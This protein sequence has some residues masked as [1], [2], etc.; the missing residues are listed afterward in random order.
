MP[1]AN[2]TRDINKTFLKNTIRN[3]ESH[4]RREETA[5]CWRQHELQ[6]QVHQEKKRKRNLPSRLGSENIYDQDRQY[7]ALL[8]VRLTDLSLSLSFL[9]SLFPLAKEIIRK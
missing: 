6:Q 4:N 1:Q 3:I 5:D 7:W 2:P 8:K 9:F